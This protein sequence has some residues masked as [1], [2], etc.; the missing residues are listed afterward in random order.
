MNGLTQGLSSDPIRFPWIQFLVQ[1]LQ[2]CAFVSLFEG[3]PFW[4]VLK[5]APE[6]SYPFWGSLTLKLINSRG[7]EQREQS[8]QWRRTSMPLR[9]TVLRRSCFSRLC[10]SLFRA[11][12]PMVNFPHRKDLERGWVIV[13]FFQ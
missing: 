8:D 1:A 10:N 4:V 9:T 5:A 6:G 11:K 2:V 3:S 13:D 12:E 7:F